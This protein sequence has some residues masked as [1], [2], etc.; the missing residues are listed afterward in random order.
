[1]NSMDYFEELNRRTI[2]ISRDENK[3][4]KD[5][6]AVP[7]DAIIKY[8]PDFDELCDKETFLEYQKKIVELKQIFRM[9]QLS[10]I[11]KLMIAYDIARIKPYSLS[12]NESLNGLPH[13][14]LSGKNISCRGYCTLLI[15]LLDSEGIKI[16]NQGLDVFDKDGNLVDGHARCSVI[17]DDG[18]KIRLSQRLS[19]KGYGSDN[20]SSIGVHD[21]FFYEQRG[22]SECCCCS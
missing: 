7:D 8:G 16:K 11:E 12:S 1:M 15:E 18:P 19:L 10:P 14:I 3:Y 21:S 22:K 17:L 2:N 9:N 4:Y 5:Y 13:E 20:S 6:S